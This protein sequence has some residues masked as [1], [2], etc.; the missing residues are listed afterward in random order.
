[1]T[2]CIRI[3]IHTYI[4]SLVAFS[5]CTSVV[6]CIAGEGDSLTER[7]AGGQAKGGSRAEKQ[8]QHAIRDGQAM[9]DPL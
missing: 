1:M 3:Y 6:S 7:N 2:V 4:Y 5:I 9:N 8:V